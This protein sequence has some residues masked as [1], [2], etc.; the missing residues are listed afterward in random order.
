[1]DWDAFIQVLGEKDH[2]WVGGFCWE[3]YQVPA[4]FGRDEDPKLG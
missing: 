2:L 4:L 3:G 1:M